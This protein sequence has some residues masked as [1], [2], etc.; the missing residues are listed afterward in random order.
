[1]SNVAVNNPTVGSHM[2]PYRNAGAPLSG[3]SG[4]LAGVARAGGLL[5]DESNGV[6]FVNEGT[7]L[8]PYWTPVGYDQAPLFGVNTDFR[9]QA[10]KAIADTGAA[11]FVP[12]SGL[13][14][15]G[16]GIEQTDS[17]LVVQTA[18]EG[19]SV[20]RL[21]ATDQADHLAAIGM[22]AGVMQPDA[23][24]L[25]VIDVELAHVSAI[26]LRA[27]FVGFLGAA[28]DALDPAITF[29]TTTA[30]FAINDLVGVCFSVDL[31][32]GDRYFTVAEA[33]N[34]GGTQDLSAAGDTGEDVAAAGTY[35]RLRVEIGADGAARAFLD[36]ADLGE[37]YGPTGA[38]VHAS[39]TVAGNP[40]E[41]YAPVVYLE[42]TSAATK[43]ADIRRFAT[44]A[45][46]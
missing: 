22:S 18:G 1:M 30:T 28:V 29:A 9:D 27:L 10:G 8:S 25:M 19:G 41:E 26:T 35:Q 45:Y 14:I 17:G 16:Q 42:S 39:G 11:A 20:G 38:G 4:T 24:Q 7:A 44:W 36:K 33:A 37:I 31:T 6:L 46:R 43:S 15:F 5:Y 12:G 3:T 32:D 23:H 40:D 13:R 34:V 21:I 2:R